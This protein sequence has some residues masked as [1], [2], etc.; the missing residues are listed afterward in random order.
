LV[1][2]ERTYGSLIRAMPK[3][4]RQRQADAATRPTPTTGR[5]SAPGGNLWSLH[6]G[7]RQLIERLL[8]R[9]GA[10][11]IAGVSVRRI[12]QLPPSMWQ[13]HGDGTARWCADALV[14]ACPSFAQ[15]GMLEPVDAELASQIGGIQYNSIAGVALGYRTADLPRSL[16]GFGYLSPGSTRRD[17]LGVLWSSSIF[18]NRSPHGTVLLQ[19]MCGGWNRPQ[20]VAW[21]DER[22][23]TAVRQELEITIGVRAA[24]VFCRVIR[25]PAA[26]PQYHIG[27]RD[28]LA[29]ISERCAL[30]P[31]LHLTGNSFRGI[32]VNDCTDNAIECAHQVVDG[33]AASGRD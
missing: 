14:L 10:E 26:I 32:S 19:A 28:R 21:D 4:R 23:V 22:I 25:W 5:R 13:V 15:A 6:N 1:E 29:A 16:D 17:V 11:L 27:H 7:M 31:G 20:I 24:P 30:L 12:E 9:S 18:E 8:E 3:V 2:L 33:L